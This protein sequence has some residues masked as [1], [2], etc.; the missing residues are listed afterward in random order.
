MFQMRRIALLC[1]TVL[2]LAACAP[3]ALPTT[4][5]S[6]ATGSGEPGAVSGKLVV[7]SGRS[8]PLI[9]PVLD[10]FQ[11]KYPDVEVLLKAGSNSELANALI[12]EQTNPQ[13][14][15]FITTELFTIQSLGQQGIFQPYR[16]S[17][18]DQ[19]DK[20]FL[21]PDD[22]W[23]GLTRRARV[24][25]YNRDL[26]AAED[27]PTSIFE[28]TD[29]KWKGKIAAAGSTNGSMQAQIAAMRQALGEAASEAWLQGLLDNEVTF[30]GGH[31]DVR[32][33]VGAGEFALG[34]VNHYYYYLQ[35]AEGSPV[36]IIFPDQGDG[37]MGLITN[38]TA[39][40]VVKGGANSAAAQ[41][42]IDFLIS[43]EGQKLFA[44]LNYE[45]PL[46]P[47]VALREGVQ[48]LDGYRLADVNVVEA[49]LESD[50]TFALMEKL[51][52]PLRTFPKN[53]FVVP[54]CGAAAQRYNKNFLV[55]PNGKTADALMQIDSY[56][57]T[58]RFRL[59]ASSTFPLPLA[60]LAGLVA[61]F[62]AVPVAYI[63]IRAAGA[64]PEAWQR[65]LQVR[66]WK[67]LGNTLLLMAAV[68][69]GALLV[70]VSMAWLTERS[71]L[72]GR[73]ILRWL[74]ALPL[75]IPTYIG[76]I[77][78]L[79]LLR[80]RGGLLPIL[81]AELAGRP[82]ATPSP[83]GF[84]GAAFIL[85]LF[86]FPYV[87]L[88]SGAA[89]RSLHASLE[90]AA[91]TLGRRPWQAVW[92]VTLPALRPGLLA[93]ALLVALDILAEYGTVALLRYETFSS[94]IFVQLSG[95]Y[96]RSAAS[97][98]S[99]V[100]VVLAV[101]IL[102]TELRAQGQA[103]FTQMESSWRPAP[104][105]RLGMW[106]APA[107]LLALGVVFTSLVVPVSVLAAWS[108][109]A[110]LDTQTLQGVLRSGSQG[111]ANFAWNSL[112]TSSLAA[113]AAVMLS[114]PVA[115]FS[116]RHPGRVSRFIA[117]FCQ[118]GYAIPGV[119]IALSL[120]LL[121][122]R[123]L[124]FLV[125]HAAR[126]GDG[127]RAAPHAA[128]GAR[129]RIRAQPAF[130]HPGRSGAHLGADSAAGIYPGDPA[131]DFA[132]PAGGRGAGVPDL[133]QRTAG[134]LAAAPGGFRHAGGAGVGVGQRRLYYPGGP[135]RLVSG[136]D[137]SAAF[138]LSLT[139]GAN[140]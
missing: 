117:R 39:A 128:G 113:I 137:L 11:A 9:Q 63:L 28:L 120:V 23:V 135:R 54:L 134:H 32:K 92:S 36:G 122:N 64:D 22:T 68:T 40:A 130:T 107:L 112:W 48:P 70:G 121:V 5:A 37:Q 123:A 114:L 140:L 67:L 3:A 34:L 98:L 99:G 97:I 49:A 38:V 6:L 25:M 83:V 55:E 124:P 13:A 87:Y 118:V 94:A 93:G 42:L 109:Q 10:A 133:A 90:E 60:G 74:F 104:P 80:P 75:A 61:L 52:L 138:V 56:P 126:G 71:D 29:P 62:V 35:Q 115:L 86:T 14:D 27:L 69:G 46:L 51:S 127:L 102:W 76:G 73:K 82:V 44:E 45:Y 19:L 105:A 139:Q 30:F 26:V 57:R 125:C 31:T 103:R 111:F 110:V 101:V 47:G 129:Q 15:V 41:A 59:G 53:N 58:T 17:G 20:E 12:E 88:L 7:Y 43:A 18:A 89:F 72:P 91:R 106:K 33:A 79:A 65:L 16:P 77:V 85:T 24:I 96:D 131:A 136:A 1:L 119:V 21:G 2:M 66:I 108:I 95:R 116:V 8:E 132:G 100:L 78:H 84:W 4:P 50:A 81:L